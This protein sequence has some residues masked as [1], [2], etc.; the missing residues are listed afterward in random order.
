MGKFLVA[1]VGASIGGSIGWWAGAPIGFMT[2]CFVSLIGTA[3][4]GYYARRWANENL[5]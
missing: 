1:S 2:A 4:G 5:P 3:V